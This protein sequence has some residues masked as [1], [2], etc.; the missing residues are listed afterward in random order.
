M[1]RLWFRKKLFSALL[2]AV[3]FFC[4]LAAVILARIRGSF[5][6]KAVRDFEGRETVFF[7]QRD[8]SWAEDKLGTSSYTMRGS[9]CLVTCIASALRMQQ[10]PVEGVEPLTPKTLNAALSDAGAYD[11]QGNLIWDVMDAAL[12]LES[13]RISDATSERIDRYLAGGIYPI[14][15]VRVRGLGGSHFVLITGAADGDYLCMDPAKRDA[16]LVPL[17][18]YADRIYAIRCVYRPEPDDD[19]LSDH[20]N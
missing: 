4:V 19:G 17:S 2:C 16:S 11:G 14:V 1:N 6:V 7:S 9:G 20:K 13:D 15:R 8:E 18:K 5:V 3:L 12:L 10:T